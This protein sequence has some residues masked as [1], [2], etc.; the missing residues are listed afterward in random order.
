[1][2]IKFKFQ[3]QKIIV[4][5]LA[6]YFIQLIDVEKLVSKIKTEKKLLLR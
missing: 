2:S 5:K 6:K 1:M 3:P 4:D